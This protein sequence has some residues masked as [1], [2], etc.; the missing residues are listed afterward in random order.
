VNRRLP[1]RAA[2]DIA[3]EFKLDQV[4]LIGYE[5]D[6]DHTFPRQM[7]H[8]VTYG[9]SKVDCLQ[10]A[11][12]GNKLKKVLGWPDSLRAEPS[13]MKGKMI[14]NRADLWNLKRWS[15]SRN[16][17]IETAEEALKAIGSILESM[18]KE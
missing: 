13:R 15:E 6:M 16:G 17:S 3:R 12:G 11:Q 1:I 7:T 14:V 18:L 10:A 9:K 4:I 8:V 5:R 2:R